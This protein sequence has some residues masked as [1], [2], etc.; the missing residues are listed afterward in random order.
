MAGQKPS[1]LQTRGG[2][3]RLARAD[4][5]LHDRSG[6]GLSDALALDIQQRTAQYG[7]GRHH[8]FHEVGLGS[9]APLLVPTT[10]GGIT[11]VRVS[12]TQ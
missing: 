8:P 10:S 12:D 7:V 2:S 6:A 9:I 4:A 11:I 5:L 1:L 3:L